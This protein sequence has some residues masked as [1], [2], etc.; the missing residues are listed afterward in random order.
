MLYS[1]VDLPERA[2]RRQYFYL[3][4]Y[5]T[6]HAELR[7]GTLLIALAMERAVD[8]GVRAIDMLRGEQAYK[9]IWHMERTPTFGLQL[10][11]RV[12][13]QTAIAAVA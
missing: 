2:E 8:E 3:T 1:V 13:R 4:A 10:S 6:A 11:R 9:Q 5:S 12:Q 7:P